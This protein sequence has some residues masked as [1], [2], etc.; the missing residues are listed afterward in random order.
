MNEKLVTQKECAELFGLTSRQIHNLVEQG[1]PRRARAGK[2]MYPWPSSLRWYLQHKD[3]QA[4]AKTGKEAPNADVFRRKLEAETRLQEIELEKEEGQ[5][6][7][8]DY[9][10]RQLTGVLSRV[11]AQLLNMPGKYA[12]TMVGVRTIAEAQTRIESMVAEAM[13]AMMEIGEDPEL[14]AGDDETPGESGMAA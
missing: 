11:R 1:M 7:A 12:P 9:M 8:L 2:A 14:D 13:A 10:E 5:L 3:Q 4:A 6:V